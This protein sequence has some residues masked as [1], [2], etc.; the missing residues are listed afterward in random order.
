M[1][2]ILTV[3]HTITQRSKQSVSIPYFDETNDLGAQEY[4]FTP[5]AHSVSL[6]RSF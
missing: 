2:F 6:S 5:D 4:I 1:E 3:T